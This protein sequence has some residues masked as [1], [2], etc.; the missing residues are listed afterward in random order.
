M[1][2][3][4]MITRRRIVEIYVVTDPER[5]GQLDLRSSKNDGR[6]NVAAR[7][8]FGSS[9]LIRYCAVC[10]LAITGQH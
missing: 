7:V 3:G 2:L 1:V 6:T 10:S 9:A 8:S 4:I 5:P